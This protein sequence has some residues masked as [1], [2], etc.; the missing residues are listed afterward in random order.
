MSGVVPAPH[1]FHLWLGAAT[2]VVTAPLLVW[3][4]A[5]AVFPQ[6]AH[7]PL[8][9]APLTVIGVALLAYQR[10]R[11]SRSDFLKAWISAVAFFL[12]ALNQVVPD[13]HWATICNDLA[14]AAFIL[15]V[16][17]VILGWPAPVTPGAA[18]VVASQ[19]PAKSARD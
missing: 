12:W 1:R 14:V 6:G 19:D 7:G 5:P 15:D 8:A 4:W 3:D 11:G 13:E 18:P 17:L 9:A 10:L 2:L 16:A